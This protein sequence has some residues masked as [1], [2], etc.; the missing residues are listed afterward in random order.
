MRELT[1]HLAATFLSAAVL[2]TG[3]AQAMEIQQY[4][5][6]TPADQ[7][8]YVR[9]LVQGAEKILN[10]E[11][12]ASLATQVSYLF[13]IKDPGDA[14]SVG[15]VEFELDL[16]RMRTDDADGVLRDPNA[17]RLEVEDAMLVTL[18]NN[19]ITLPS[20]FLSVGKDFK[21][22]FPPQKK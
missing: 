18:K 19:G 14:Q 10:E 12:K 22:K 11:G 5:K 1:M 16:D 17:R 21:P 13:T 6:M 2:F 3:A 4:D 9:L 20:T 8:E 15:M 7:S